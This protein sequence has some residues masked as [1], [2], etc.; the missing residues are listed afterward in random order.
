MVVAS[1]A[2]GTA[3]TMVAKAR[4]AVFA[5]VHGKATEAVAGTEEWA[6]NQCQPAI[7]EQ[8]GVR[9][10]WPAPTP[11]PDGTRSRRDPAAMAERLPV[12]KWGLP[13]VN[14]IPLAAP[15][16]PLER[17]WRA[18]GSEAI[19]GSTMA[20]ASVARASV[21]EPSVAKTG[22]VEDGAAEVGEEEAGVDGAVAGVIPA[23][24]LAGDAGPADGDLDLVGVLTGILFGPCIRILTGAIWGGVI[25]TATTLR[26]TISI[27]IPLR[28]GRVAWAKVV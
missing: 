1:T 15:T 3:A 25:L 26:P 28:A 7:P 18:P 8:P 16:V 2:V 17:R 19:A 12:I 20:P 11:R 23:T 14:G 22:A 6:E 13:T 27:L 4:T 5:A 24:D 10:H 21:A 9:R